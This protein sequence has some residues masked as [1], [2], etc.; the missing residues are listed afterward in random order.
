MR[1]TYLNTEL[2]HLTD[3]QL[4][5]VMRACKPL[6]PLERRTFL[7]GVADRLQGYREIGDGALH[8]L[9]MELQRQHF[10]PPLS[11]DEL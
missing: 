2:F 3:A 4:G 8:R 6:Q 11:V 5:A 9:L 10:S 1:S 7:E